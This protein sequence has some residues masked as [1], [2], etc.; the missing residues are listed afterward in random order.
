MLWFASLVQEIASCLLDYGQNC[1]QF[2]DSILKCIF[3]KEIVWILL[4]ISMKV[5]SEGFEKKSVLVLVT[6]WH[7]TSTIKLIHHL[8]Q[9][10]PSSLRHYVSPG[11]RLNIKTI[12]PGMGI[13]MLKI[14]RSRDRLIFNMGIPI[15]V[16]WHLHIETAPW[17]Q[18]IIVYKIWQSLRKNSMRIICVI[19]LLCWESSCQMPAMQKACNG[20]FQFNVEIFFLGIGFPIMQIRYSW[21]VSLCWELLRHFYL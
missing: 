19:G 10:W 4:K 3:L 5:V 1:Q 21:S 7:L 16:R 20:G 2:V 18:W 15:L 14:R 8:K 13:P 9:W 6:V 12:F 17:P 11:P